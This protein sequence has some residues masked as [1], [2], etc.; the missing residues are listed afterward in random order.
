MSGCWTN[1]PWKC[2]NLTR[3]LWLNV[4]G[5]KAAGAKPATEVPHGLD[6]SWQFADAIEANQESVSGRMVAPYNIDINIPLIGYVG[7]SADGV[8]PGDVKWQVDY[9]WTAIGESTIAA[10]DET[11]T[12]IGTASATPNGLVLA[13][14]LGI[15]HPSITKRCITFKI[16]RLS[17]DV[18]DTI[19]DTT[20]LIGVCLRYN[21]LS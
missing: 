17:G 21:V 8:S 16:T 20:E 19:A 9:N 12:G 11:L 2:V 15:N 3:E 5:L 18:L 6:T 10:A 13:E 14:I 1:N 4:A 7:W